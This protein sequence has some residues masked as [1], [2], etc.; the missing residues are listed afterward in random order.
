MNSAEQR[1]SLAQARRM[2]DTYSDVDGSVPTLLEKLQSG[3][4]IAEGM[5]VHWNPGGAVIIDTECIPAE[6]WSG[7]DQEQFAADA[8]TELVQTDDG[9]PYHF[10]T[11]A[12]DAVCRAL[13]GENA[14]TTRPLRANPGG[15]PRVFD[16]D[17]IWMATCAA[18]H[19]YGMPE[20]VAGMIELM[21]G[22]CREHSLA[23]PAEE[24][25]KPKAR[26][27]LSY[28]HE[29]VDAPEPRTNIV[30]IDE[31]RRF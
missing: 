24:T 7:Y 8:D 14:S 22:A 2:F 3:A 25:L 16:W 20:T 19:R 10:P 28:L 12:A 17:K 13:A 21:Q 9:D 23:E 31:A 15:R 26:A 27:L 1:V 6:I 30:S 4:L 29:A 18:V 5:H 11:I